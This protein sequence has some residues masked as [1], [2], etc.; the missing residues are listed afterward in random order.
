MKNL[1]LLISLFA[2]LGEACSAT[3]ANPNCAQGEH[4][5]VENSHFQLL[6]KKSNVY[7]LHSTFNPMIQGTSQR[8]YAGVQI[9]DFSGTIAAYDIKTGSSLWQQTFSL[10]VNLLVSD[11]NLYV[12]EYNK[13]VVHDVETGNPKKEIN[14]PKVGTIQNI[15]ASGENLY[16]STGNG[17]WVVYNAN[18]DEAE[19]SEPLLPYAPFVIEN[20]ILYTNDVEGFKAVDTNTQ[21]VLW[22]YSV[23][24]IINPHPLFTSDKIIVPTQNGRVYALNKN[25]GDLLWSQ[26]F[27]LISNLAADSFHLFF[28]SKAGFL[29][30]VDLG[31]GQEIQSLGFSPATF[32]TSTSDT[33]VGGYNIWV[34]SESEIAVV[35][36]GYSCQLMALQLN[37]P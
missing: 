14:L 20:E 31:T 1:L 15:Y 22:K 24:D 13:L 35:S 18:K 32:Q 37:L 6:W 2:I 21:S 26:D 29:K 3:R 5:L 7:S 25:T 4:E 30:V 12:G 17:S 10:P 8:V 36:L 23:D 34:D 27:D 28:L 9:R 33:I 16:I 11:T 19:I